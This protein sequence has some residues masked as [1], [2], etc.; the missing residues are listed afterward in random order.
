MKRRSGCFS[1]DET[2]LL[3]LIAA[4]IPLA[5]NVLPWTQTSSFLD[6]HNLER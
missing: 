1:F 6:L 5:Q 3:R 4:S 2:T